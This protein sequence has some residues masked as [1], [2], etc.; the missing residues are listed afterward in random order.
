MSLP[1]GVPLS[2]PSSLTCSNLQG[3]TFNHGQIVSDSGQ[4]LLQPGWSELFLILFLRGAKKPSIYCQEKKECLKMKSCHTQEENICGE[5]PRRPESAGHLSHLPSLQ[6]EVGGLCDHTRSGVS[7]TMDK[8]S[9]VLK[10][11]SCKNERIN[12]HTHTHSDTPLYLLQDCGKAYECPHIRGHA[13]L[14]PHL[15]C[16]C[17]SCLKGWRALL[18][19]SLIL[20]PSVFA[21]DFNLHVLLVAAA[22]LRTPQSHSQPQE[23]LL[24]RRGFPTAS[25]PSPSWISFGWGTP[26]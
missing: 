14:L 19:R 13:M 20:Q 10:L 22:S 6:N 7:L 15:G 8:K 11:F 23:G 4:I 1:S 26:L 12:T 16:V 18:P 17:S 9:L 2:I 24:P 25:A 21:M 5:Q 3:D